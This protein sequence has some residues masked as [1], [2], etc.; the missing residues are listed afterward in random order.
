[1]A[2][3]NKWAPEGMTAVIEAMGN[4]EVG[5]YKA[6]RIFNIPLTS[7]SITLKTGRGA[8]LKR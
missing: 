2:Q 6:S 1:M 4:K 8:Q 7:W 3:R 5:S